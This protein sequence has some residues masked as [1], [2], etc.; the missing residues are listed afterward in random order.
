MMREHIH[1]PKIKLV[2]GRGSP[3]YKA[4][5]ML[6]ISWCRMLDFRLPYIKHL[7]SIAD[8]YV[9]EHVVSKAKPHY[10]TKWCGTTYTPKSLS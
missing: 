3:S 2:E 9:Y 7:N 5:P 1:P 4:Q 10:D 6:V 8:V